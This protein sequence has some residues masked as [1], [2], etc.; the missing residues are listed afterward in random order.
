M[1]TKYVFD[2]GAECA[3]EDAD[4]DYVSTEDYEK[5]E[6]ALLIMLEIEAGRTG[7]G[8]HE[9]SRLA[10]VALSKLLGD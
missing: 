5:V 2:E 8:F 7:H 10:K 9:S 1:V 6:K 4:G 3:W